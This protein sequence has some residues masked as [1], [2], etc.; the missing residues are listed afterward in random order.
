MKVSQVLLTASLYTIMASILLIGCSSYSLDNSKN[1]GKWKLKELQVKANWNRKDKKIPLILAA[2]PKEVPDQYRL[3]NIPPAGN[4]GSQASG[5]AWAVGYFAATRLQRK[6]KENK[7]YQCAPAFIYNCLNG[8][9]DRGIEIVSALEHLKTHGCP[10]EKYMLYIAQ[11][12]AHQPSSR[13]RNNAQKY[14]INGFGRVEYTDL[15]QVRAHL[16]QNK[17]IIVTMLI[18]ENFTNLDDA[19]WT[20]PEGQALGLHTLAI[21]GYDDTK[22]IFFLLNSVGTKWATKGQTTIPYSWFIRLIKKA[23]VMW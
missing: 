3:D 5:V 6:K 17:P 19:N 23:Y 16:L 22:Q 4:Q 8:G 10:E 15:D 1:R 9:I 7:H 21:I 18:S 14:R 12:P 13:A 11:D 2:L 20:G